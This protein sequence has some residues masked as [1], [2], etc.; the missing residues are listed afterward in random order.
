L[1]KPRR[2]DFL[3]CVG[4]AAATLATRAPAAP[5]AQPISVERFGASG[6]GN[7]DDSLAVQAAIDEAAAKGGADVCVPAGV[8]LVRGLRLRSNVR[9]LGE[10]RDRTVLRETTGIS[11][12]LS[13]NPGNEGSADPSLNQ[14]DI[15]IA[16]IAFEGPVAAMGFA[17]HQHLLN[18]NGV[19]RL[20]VHDCAIRGFR[21][22]GIYLGS[23]NVAGLERHNLDV[24]LSGNEFDGITGDN[25]NGVSVI[26]GDRVVISNNRFVRCS[27]STMPGP[28]DIEPDGHPFQRISNIIIEENRF[29]DC[30]GNI[31]KIAVHIPV[32]EGFAGAIR[33]LHIARNTVG[34]RQRS[35]HA[36]YVRVFDASRRRAS[37]VTASAVQV[38]DNALASGKA[39]LQ[40]IDHFVIRGNN[41]GGRSGGLV[42]G[43][44]HAGQTDVADEGTIASNTFRAPS[45]RDAPLVIGRARRIAIS[46]NQFASPEHATEPGPAIILEAFRRQPLFEGLTLDGNLFANEYRVHLIS[47]APLTGAQLKIGASNKVLNGGKITAL[48]LQ[49]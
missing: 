33:N 11:Y 4:A 27:R 42:V 1:Q 7:V 14:H 47:K 20:H 38:L 43:A 26:D 5:R 36:L 35:G 34:A 41:F 13:V 9:L 32:P 18:F 16:R 29:E 40:G 39:M 15:E 2:R 48:G 10:G 19:T 49:P 25:R 46:D 28:I 3:I 6:K 12:L 45:N 31:A 21:G 17:E 24:R 44:V 22:D 37:P 30:G 23:G 8:Y